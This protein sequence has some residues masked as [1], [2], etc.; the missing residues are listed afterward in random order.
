VSRKRGTA[1]KKIFLY[2]LV[3]ILAFSL[4]A[5]TTFGR[6]GMAKTPEE[7][8]QEDRERTMAANKV[9]FC[10]EDSQAG[11][12]AYITEFILPSDCELPLG[13]V[14]DGERVWYL[15][16]KQGTLGNYNLATG[17]FEEFDI[18]SWPARSSPDPAMF[19]MTWSAKVDRDGNVWFTDDRQNLLWRF[20]TENSSF[21]SFR[22]PAGGPIAFDF[23]SNGN[24]YLVGVRS[25]SLYFGELSEMNPGTLDGF[26]EIKLPLDAF[27]SI[28]FGVVSGSVTVDRQRNAVWTSVLAFDQKGQI[29][30]YDAVANEI[31]VFDLPADLKSPVGTAVDNEGNV[32]VTDHA[33]NIFF[34]LD[35]DTSDITRYTTSI[36]SQRILGA[37]PS[38]GA[39]TLP[40]WIEA[41]VDGNLWFNQH[42][43]NKINKFDPSTQTMVE[44][45]IPTQNPEWANC[46]EGVA[47]CGVANALQLSVGPSGQVWFTEWTENKIGTV[48]ANEQVP[49]AVSAPDEITVRRG[50]SAE[51]RVDVTSD[52]SLAVQ[53]VASGT[54]TNTGFLGSSTGI[55]S[56][57][58]ITVNTGDARQVSFVF[59]P[60]TDLS[61]G[62]YN[63]MLGA[64]QGDVAVFKAVRVNIV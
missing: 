37:V 43:G 10:G 63:L 11:S 45:W 15:S 8:A 12:T 20:N 16:T 57:E 23:D 40:Y 56:Q 28:E 60:A 46:A 49:L 50:D 6:G 9:R 64:D 39:Y 3:G 61:P 5:M 51:I 29:F 26:T 36:L 52:A 25:S 1:N 34:M 47:E 38:S 62:Q 30:R 17:R 31:A 59:T 44:Y 27:S 13:I 42:V 33:T 14:V 19:S 53:M 4:V 7:L 54:F 32:W 2:I 41:D 18:P 35:P 55:F 24:I 58:S 22:S 21:D 48:R